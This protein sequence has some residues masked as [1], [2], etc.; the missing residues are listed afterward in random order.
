MVTG[1]LA[2]LKWIPLVGRP[3]LK[4]AAIAYTRGFRFAALP[5][6]YQNREIVPELFGVI[7]TDDITNLLVKIIEKDEMAEIGKR[8]EVFD[9]EEDPAEEIIRHILG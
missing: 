4:K 6:I 5:N 2:V 9:S 8:L 7:K 1:V 3:I